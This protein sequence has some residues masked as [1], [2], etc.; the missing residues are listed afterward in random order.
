MKG[1]ES[2]SLPA[3]AE[4]NVEQLFFMSYASMWCETKTLESLVSQLTG[5]PHPPHSVRIWGTMQNSPAFAKAFTCKAED[6][7][8]PEQRCKIW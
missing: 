2:P 6:D 4:Y 1:Q 3:L 8:V 7:L 5:D